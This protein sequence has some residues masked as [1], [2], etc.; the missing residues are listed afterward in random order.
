M[1][2]LIAVAQRAAAPVQPRL[3]QLPDKVVKVR[4]E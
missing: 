1:L 3:H 2:T 4:K